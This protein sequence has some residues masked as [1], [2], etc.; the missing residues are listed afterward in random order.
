MS[1]QQGHGRPLDLILP[2]PENRKQPCNYV[3]R[4]QKQQR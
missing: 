4:V 1:V 2:R 3:W